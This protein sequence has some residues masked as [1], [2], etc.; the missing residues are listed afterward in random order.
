M[1]ITDQ[2]RAELWPGRRTACARQAGV[3]GVIAHQP[4]AHLL[5]KAMT[6]SAHDA[7]LAAAGASPLAASPGRRRKNLIGT[8]AN[9]GYENTAAAG[10]LTVRQLSTPASSP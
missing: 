9:Y 10:P 3:G 4:V 6:R 1:V 5:K 2:V 8:L 7:G